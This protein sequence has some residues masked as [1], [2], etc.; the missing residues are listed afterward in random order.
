MISRIVVVTSDVFVRRLTPALASFVR[1][2]REFRIIDIHRP[3]RELRQLIRASRPAAI[4]TEWL[5]KTTAMV[6]KLG[7]PT[8]I[9]DTDEI[10]PGT[11]SIDVD[12]RKVGEIA[13]QFF[14]DAGYR[15]F[16]CVYFRSSYAIQRR[17]GF[18]DL[19]SRHGHKCETFLH[20]E[21]E[22]R[23]YMESWQEPTVAM[24]D[25]L[26][27]RPKPAGIFAIHDPLGRMVCEAA[28]EERLQLPDEVAVVGANNDELVCGLSYPPLSSV[29]IPWHRIGALAGKWAQSLLESTAPPKTALLVPPGPVIQRQSTTLTAVDDSELRRALQYLRERNSEEITIQMMCQELRISRRS[30][31]RKFATH[32]HSTPR[33]TL[34]RMRTE[35]AKRLLIETDLPMALIADRSGFGNAERFSVVFRQQT[36]LSPSAFRKSAKG[37]RLPPNNASSPES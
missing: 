15:H 33:D 22:T 31:E 18:T 35:S 24:R 25:W 14:L 2:E 4:I 1:D 20:P 19:L 16:G 27:S 12:D 3:F 5:P 37:K 30:L 17:Q 28:M 36:G 9:A 7:Y 21:P 13:A 10:Y 11:V 32:L 6:V 29:A 26:R 23:H 34:C 8:V